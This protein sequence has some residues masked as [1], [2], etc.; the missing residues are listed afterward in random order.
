MGRAGGA[1]GS[2]SGEGHG[3][4]CREGSGCLA[5]SEPRRG[6]YTTYSANMW[7]TYHGAGRGQEIL[8]H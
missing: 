6:E 7:K 4:R 3:G 5:Q 1:G 2:S 8:M